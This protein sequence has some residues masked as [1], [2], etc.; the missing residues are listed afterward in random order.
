M[1]DSGRDPVCDDCQTG[2]RAIELAGQSNPKRRATVGAGRTVTGLAVAAP[3]DTDLDLGVDRPLAVLEGR[4][5]RALLR[6]RQVRH[7]WPL[8]RDVE[9]ASPERAIDG[10]DLAIADVA[11]GAGL[12]FEQSAGFEIAAAVSDSGGL[13]TSVELSVEIANR[14][15]APGGQIMIHGQPNEPRHP[16]QYYART[17]WTDGCIAVSDADMVDIWLMTR[18]NT[19]VVIE[20]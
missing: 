16:E 8:L 4:S 11:D 12:D 3:C 20:P 10:E 2:R 15:E 18:S 17:D 13:S 9:P 14:N 6:F 19:P 1:T 7:R 5:E